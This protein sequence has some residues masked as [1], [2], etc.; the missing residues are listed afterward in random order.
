[1]PVLPHPLFLNVFTQLAEFIEPIGRRTMF[2]PPVR[3]SSNSLQ[4]Q[5]RENRSCTLWDTSYILSSSKSFYCSGFRMKITKSPYSFSL[6]KHSMC[7]SRQK[8]NKATQLT[9]GGLLMAWAL[10]SD[11]L[12]FKYQ[13]RH[14]IALWFVLLPLRNQN[15]SF[16]SVKWDS[17]CSVISFK[18]DNICNI[19][20]IVLGTYE[21]LVIVSWL[22]TFKFY[23]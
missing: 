10:W 6:S 18:W 13:L 17:M 16:S 5:S 7:C 9:V 15:L 8:T 2:L 20:Q 14:L 22:L 4:W 21:M 12:G 3:N 19:L 1:M 11:R 23:F